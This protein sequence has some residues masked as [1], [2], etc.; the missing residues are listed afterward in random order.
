MVTTATKLFT[1]GNNNNHGTQLGLDCLCTMATKLFT[2]GQKRPKGI[3][4]FRYK[5]PMDIYG[6]QGMYFNKGS[7]I[8]L[9]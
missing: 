4:G 9:S 1:V 7:E 2:L 5:G 6:N 3:D 8:I